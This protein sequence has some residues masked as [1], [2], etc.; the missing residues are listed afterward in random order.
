MIITREPQKV[1]AGAETALYS[2]KRQYRVGDAEEIVDEHGKHV[3]W[4]V[5]K[6]SYKKDPAYTASANGRTWNY[7]RKYFRFVVRK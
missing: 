2:E 3:A 7:G 6:G 1:V 4:A 5:C